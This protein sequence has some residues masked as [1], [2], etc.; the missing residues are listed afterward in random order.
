[1]PFEPSGLGKTIFEERYARE[2]ESWDAASLRVASHIAQ[3]EENGKQ[4]KWTERFYGEIVDGRFMPGGRIWY[5]SGRPKGQLL[6]CFV[7]PT[8]DS[9]EGW[10]R[11]ISDVIVVSG[12]GGGVGINGSPIRPRGANIAGTGGS[13]TGPVSL[14]Q[15][16]DRVGDVLRGGG[17]RRLA[18]MLAL[19][20]SHPDLLEFLDVKLDREQLTNAN[21]SV[22][23]NTAT[24]QLVESIR[25]GGRLPSS[26]GGVSVGEGPSA[27]DVWAKIVYNAWN[28]GEPGVLNGWLANQQSNIWYHKPLICTNPCGEIWLEE[29]GSCDL[30]ALVLPRYVSDGVFNWDQ[31]DSSVRSA[32][33]FLDNVLSVN[34]YPLQEIADGN[35]SVR[36]LGLGVMGLHTS[37]LDMGMAYD[38]DEAYSFVDKLSST[39]KNT[40]YDASI[41]LAIEKGPFPVYDQRLLESGFAK[42]LKRGI[43]NK[44]REH[45]LRNCALLTIAPTGTTGMVQGVSTGIEPLFAPVYRRRYWSGED[46]TK[47]IV[48]TPEFER[49]GELAQGAYD[50]PVENHFKMQA[51]VQ[52][53]ID[54]AVSKT[55]N[56][57]FDY[58]AEKLSEVW[59]EY[60]PSIKGSTFYRQGSRGEEPLE[61]IS[62]DEVTQMSEGMVPAGIEAAEAQ[63]IMDCVNGVCSV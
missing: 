30:G 27:A 15:M 60:L 39:L 4:T 36:R 25:S 41:N 51:T 58:P 31:F 1:M 11:T 62:V 61:P 3:A 6:N 9:R 37:L 23:F 49:Y 29:Y 20:V 17:G 35:T 13:A 50:I 47:E 34:H 14:M 8:S 40:A 24:E 12:L 7:V 54:N 63:Y 33:R 26:F 44:I 5:G 57:P 42:T 38:S 28:S 32:V 48:I 21:V 53:H 59:L 10:G 55:I 16:V 45:G 43:R 52:K 18:L 46:R 19:D 56:L 2:G 22:I